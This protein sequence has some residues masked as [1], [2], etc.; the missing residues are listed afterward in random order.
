MGVDPLKARLTFQEYFERMGSNESW[1]K[2][3]AAL[4]GAYKAQLDYGTAAIGGKDSMSGTFNDIHVP[5]TLV[6]FAVGMSTTDK[7]ITATLTGKGQKLYLIKCARDGKGSYKKDHV[8][9]VIKAVKEITGLGLK[10]A[11]ALVEEAP[12]AV[13]EAAPKAEAEDIKAKLEAAGA[14]VEL[15]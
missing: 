3:L 14:T 7:I 9:R 6:S 11:K 12:K 13:K 15:K 2:P 1:G 10:E 5:P 4:L 8:L